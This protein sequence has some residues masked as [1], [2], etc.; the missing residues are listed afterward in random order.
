MAGLRYYKGWHLVEEE[1]LKIR[2][3]GSGITEFTFQTCLEEAHNARIRRNN[4]RKLS[5]PEVKG[6]LTAI[7]ELHSAQEPCPLTIDCD[8]W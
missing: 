6:A 4:L 5:Q 2:P 8:R 3:E 7:A 1:L